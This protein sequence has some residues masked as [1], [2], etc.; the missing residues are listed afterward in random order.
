[1]RRGDTSNRECYG[2]ISRRRLA[3]G[4]SGRENRAG[5]QEMRFVVI[6][7]RRTKIV[8]PGP[9]WT[10]GVWGE[11]FR[12]TP[13]YRAFGHEGAAIAWPDMKAN[14]NV[15]AERIGDLT[16]PLISVDRKTKRRVR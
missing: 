6:A 12:S 13:T 16:I 1:M 2:G 7:G 9:P 4:C 5:V 14:P 15:A 3:H 10:G 8:S 11:A